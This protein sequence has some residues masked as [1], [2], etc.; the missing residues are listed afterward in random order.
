MSANLVRGT[1]EAFSHLDNDIL[2][3][4][5]VNSQTLSVEVGNASW[6]QSLLDRRILA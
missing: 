1:S 2:F 5:C 4:W 6:D 3:V